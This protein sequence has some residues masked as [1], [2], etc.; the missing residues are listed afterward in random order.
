MT[1]ELTPIMI[2]ADQ[3]RRYKTFSLV[4][5]LKS[6]N[7]PAM[8]S[9]YLPVDVVWTR[10]SEAI[11]FDIKT[12]DDFIASYTDGRFY[13]QIKSMHEA[14]CWMFGILIVL[15]EGA[16]SRDP[17]H[18]I[19]TSPHAWTW[20]QFMDAKL[21]LEQLGGVKITEAA[22]KLQLAKRIAAIWHWTGKDE[23][24]S[25]CSPFPIQAFN[26]LTNRDN[27]IIF[28]DEMFRNHVGTLM[29][30]PGVGLKTANDLRTQ[31][32]LMDLL[33]TTEE[34][35]AIAKEKWAAIKGV[36]P[37]TVRSFEKWIRA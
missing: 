4:E 7:V 25:W 24:A 1:R 6:F 14:N 3:D 29:H 34:G 23:A 19:G 21:D 17:G 31:F 36:G 37:K 12:I 30:I 35:I 8:S 10:D 27:P 13:S 2:A 16:Y 33:G 11:L 5:H 32:S 28:Y 15:E 18:L 9:L 20:D 22:G 26:D